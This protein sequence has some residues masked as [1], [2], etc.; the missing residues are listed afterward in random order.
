MSQSMPATLEKR[1]CHTDF[2]LESLFLSQFHKGMTGHPELIWKA[3]NGGRTMS[4]SSKAAQGVMEANLSL[5]AFEASKVDQIQQQLP[6][7][8]RGH[9]NTI[10][11]LL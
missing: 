10:K 5:I 3:E 7:R 2:A 9:R 6:E 4:G 8:G 1:S 11:Q